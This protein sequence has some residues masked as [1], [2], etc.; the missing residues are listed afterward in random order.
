MRTTKSP[1][2]R[3]VG[4]KLGEVRA[5]LRE[6]ELRLGNTDKYAQKRA[7]T[8]SGIQAGVMGLRLRVA[9]AAVLTVP[10]LF[11]YGSGLAERRTVQRK[12]AFQ[13]FVSVQG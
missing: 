3:L 9:I 5:L 1:P 2:Q 13:L 6:E 4:N 12:D 11:T 8:Q 7:R 10:T